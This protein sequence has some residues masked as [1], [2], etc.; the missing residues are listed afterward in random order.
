MDATRFMTTAALAVA[1]A[2]L[3]APPVV[4]LMSASSPPVR[5]SSG[6]DISTI[7]QSTI[8]QDVGRASLAGA[9]APDALMCEPAAAA[10]TL[11]ARAPRIARAGI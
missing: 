6:L 10:P 8:A 7:G 2:S 3:F 11:A 1:M 4:G 5:P 9:R